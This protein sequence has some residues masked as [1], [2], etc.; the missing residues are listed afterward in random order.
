NSIV[1]VIYDRATGRPLAFNALA[2]MQVPVHGR[3]EEVLHLGLVMID[4]GSRSQ[5]FSWILYG[6][7]CLVLF[8]RNQFRPLWLSSVTQV[9]AV[10]G[11]VSQTFSDVFPSADDGAR[12]SFTHLVLA[13]RIMAHHR[14]AFGVG[15]EAEFDEE[16]FII[17][18]AYTGGSDD[19]KKTYADAP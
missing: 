2:V 5:G 7:T 12:R 19:L 11:M 9:P 4:P 14:A 15:P 6:L 16:R 17:R 10:V 18:N 3:P 13:R 1:T 8:V